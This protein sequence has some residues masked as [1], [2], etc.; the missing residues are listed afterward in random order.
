MSHFPILR[1]FPQFADSLSYSL[2]LTQRNSPKTRRFKLT[3]KLR[4]YIQKNRRN[5]DDRYQKSKA[6][7]VGRIVASQ[8]MDHL[9]ADRWSVTYITSS[10]AICPRLALREELL[11]SFLASFLDCFSS[12]LAISDPVH[13]S[14]RSMNGKVAGIAGKVHCP[15]GEFRRDQ[16]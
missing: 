13:R 2:L 16:S 8:Q 7:P 15:T 3:D 14:Q 10:I 9:F 12:S 11:D 1:Q 4:W 6:I 5:L